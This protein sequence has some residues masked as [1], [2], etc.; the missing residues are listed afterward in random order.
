MT[1]IKGGIMAQK[2]RKNILERAKGY[3]GIRSKKERYAHEAL[4]RAGRYAFAHRR[5][6]K[7][8]FR[9]LWIVRLN[10]AVR[11]NGHASYSTF[12]NKLKKSG[13][14]LDRKVLAQFASEHPAI[15]SRIAKQV[16]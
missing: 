7:T 15:F 14:K 13:F 12:I 16:I 11:E 1:R 5:D 6:K 10:A 4:M 9:Q 8:D 3:R 2:R